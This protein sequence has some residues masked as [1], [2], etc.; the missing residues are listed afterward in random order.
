VEDFTNGIVVCMTGIFIM[1][2]LGSGHGHDANN[3]IGERNR[4]DCRSAAADSVKVSRA[5][6]QQL[7][8]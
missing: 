3:A 1:S 7:R 6:T 4:F 5:L 2:G 8:N